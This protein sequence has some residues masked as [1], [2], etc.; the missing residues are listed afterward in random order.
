MKAVVFEGEGRW[1]LL[2]RP[3]P[4]IEAP[5]DVLL[6]VEACGICGTDKHIL[7][8]PPSYI[9]APG[10]VLGHEFV[11]RVVEVGSAVRQLKRGD[12][13]V[14]DPSLPCGQCAYCQMGLPNVCLNM[15]FIGFFRDGALASLTTAPASSCYPIADG[16]PAPIAALAQPL[17][18]VVN[19]YNLAQLRSGETVLVLGAGPIGLL[20]AQVMK[21]GGATTVVV[22]EVSQKRREQAVHIGADY[23]VD[24]SN[25]DLAEVIRSL[26]NG[27]GADVVVDAVGTLLPQAIETARRGGRIVA[28]GMNREVKPEIPAYTVTNHSLHIYGSVRAPY[29]FPAAIRLIESGVLN[30]EEIVTHRPP[31]ENFGEAIELL[32]SGKALKVALMIAETA[33]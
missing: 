16:V 27:L 25:E 28:F 30:L 9:A 12:R 3:E 29:T 21:A 7:D 19:G 22:S 26:T 5:S 11:A 10:T 17:A 20:F 4:T 31:L 23:V 8:V 18:C 6:A 1:G 15:E 13:V 24:P 14:V 33:F 2:E 32:R